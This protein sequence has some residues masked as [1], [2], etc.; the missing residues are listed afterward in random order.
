MGLIV[1]YKGTPFLSEEASQCFF[2][3]FISYSLLYALRSYDAPYPSN[4]A[5]PLPEL[6]LP[7]G[8]AKRAYGKKCNNPWKYG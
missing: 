1:F 4:E 6:I 2:R 8:E 5:M 7:K 3:A